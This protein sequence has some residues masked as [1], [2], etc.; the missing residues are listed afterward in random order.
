MDKEPLSVRRLPMRLAA[1][2]RLTITRLF[3]AGPSR[4]RG[5][6]DRVVAL[7]EE[8]ASGLLTST[9]NEFGHLHDG[10]ED[11]FLG[12]YEQVARRVEMPGRLTP[13]RKLLIGAYFT[14]EYSFASS[15]IFN[16]SITPAV[17]QD[18]VE[19]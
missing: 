8:E 9:M 19:P 6:I 1:D 10:L 4:A 18:G 17:A 5:L 15:A 12:H 14:L 13:T 3:W 7:S 16:P 11:I 2:A